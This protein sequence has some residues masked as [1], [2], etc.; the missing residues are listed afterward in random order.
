MLLEIYGDVVLDGAGGS[1]EHSRICYARDKRNLQR[2]M[3][4]SKFLVVVQD[5]SL[6]KLGR[7]TFAVTRHAS[8]RSFRNALGHYGKDEAKAS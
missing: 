3:N 2:L 6:R 4:L 7:G 5:L 8:T 1:Q